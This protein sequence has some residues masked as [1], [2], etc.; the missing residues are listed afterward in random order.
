MTTE[1][2]ETTGAAPQ[3]APTTPAIQRSQSERFT[4]LVIREFSTNAGMVPDLTIF[5][6]RLVS[7]YFLIVDRNLRKAEQTRLSKSER[8]RDAVPVT[9]E[10]INMAQLAI[11]VVAAA[12]VGLDPAQPNH[13]N[14]LPFKNNASGKYDLT[15]IVGYRGCELKAT[16]Y[17]LNFP[18]DVVCE[19]VY[20][21]DKFIQI[22][23]DL[24]N[25]VESYIFEVTDNFNRGT[26]VGGFYY[27][28][29]LDKPEK[30]KLRVFSMA[31]I[32]KRKPAYASVDFWGG[33]KDIWENNVKTGTKH[34]DGWLDEMAFKTLCRAAY[35]SITIDSSKIDDDF[36][37]V[38]ERD[39]ES[40]W[41]KQDEQ[42]NTANSKI[43]AIDNL[44]TAEEVKPTAPAPETANAPAPETANATA[45]E[46]Q[47]TQ[48]QIPGFGTV[49]TN[50]RKPNF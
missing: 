10:N 13:I 34:V 38:T 44:Q 5:Q 36:M 30:N 32:E 33:E 20:S 43:L 9:W 8:Y 18:D 21:T 15:F 11:D 29:F 12:R 47:P 40:Q 41:K 14:I 45:P 42:P 31:D 1:N 28:H 16:K 22:K 37:R 48:E 39:A 4:N 17:G 26:I 46:A 24:N 49:G 6:K 7:N 23:K 50:K 19:L 27:H 3:T 25:R 35:N 2:K